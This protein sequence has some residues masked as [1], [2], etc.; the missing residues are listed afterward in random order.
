MSRGNEGK[1]RE[2]K[3]IPAVF[4]M[5]AQNGLTFCSAHLPVNSE[6]GRFLRNFQLPDLSDF[7]LNYALSDRIFL[8]VR[9]IAS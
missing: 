4:A 9:E 3:D 1:R 2:K 8:N 6:R 5:T 7:F